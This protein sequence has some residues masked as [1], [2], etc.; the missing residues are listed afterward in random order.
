MKASKIIFNIYICIFFLFLLVFSYG[1]GGSGGH[2]DDDSTFIITGRVI[3]PEEA[4]RQVQN[5]KSEKVTLWLEQQPTISTTCDENGYFTL[6][7]P[8]ISDSVN[9]IAFKGKMKDN[10]FRLQRSDDIFLTKEKTIN[11]GEL[12]LTPGKNSFL[13]HISDN[14][15]NPIRYAQCSFWGFEILSDLNGTINFPKFPE[16]ITKIKATI[17]ASGM[18]EFTDEFP[19]FTEDLGPDIGLS[20]YSYRDNKNPI[21]LSIDKYDYEPNPGQIVNFLVKIDDQSNL[22]NNKRDVFWFCNEGEILSEKENS[23]VWRAPPYP[24]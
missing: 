17:K 16:N 3:V 11:I 4:S 9:L 18:K 13:I 7:V 1:C 23:L 21:V 5:V 8:K 15:F 22:L 2:K 24:C 20:V 12:K 19:V 6:N 14:Y 10:D